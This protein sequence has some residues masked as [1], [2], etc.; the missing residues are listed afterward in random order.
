M[1]QVNT[2]AHYSSQKQQ[3]ISSVVW[4]VNTLL[5]LSALHLLLSRP[6]QM[7]VSCGPLVS[8]GETRGRG[9]MEPQRTSN[10]SLNLLLTHSSV[11]FLSF[12]YVS[13][14]LFDLFLHTFSD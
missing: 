9:K 5:S 13:L 8:R 14:M 1:I 7:V 2:F 6:G 10:F 12:K 4:L 11:F 3:H